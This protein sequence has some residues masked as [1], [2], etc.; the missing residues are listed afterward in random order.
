MGTTST[1]GHWESY[2][3]EEIDPEVQAYITACQNLMYT[4]GRIAQRAKGHQDFASN[5]I[6]TCRTAVVVETENL[7]G[8]YYDIYYIPCRNSFFELA[9]SINEQCDA[10][11]AEIQDRIDTLND[12]IE[13]KKP[14]LYH[15]VTKQ[16]WVS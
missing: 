3:E 1:S 16:R 13:A 4:L 15:T 2:E 11:L 8:E 6:E 14:Y 5:A 10:C 12:L 7:S 9:D